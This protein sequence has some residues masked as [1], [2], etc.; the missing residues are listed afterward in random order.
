MTSENKYV[1]RPLQP[2]FLLPFG[3]LWGSPAPCAQ[4][5]SRGGAGSAG[6][7]TGSPGDHITPGWEG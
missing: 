4:L 3:V 7:L 5:S 6:G 2:E 1:M